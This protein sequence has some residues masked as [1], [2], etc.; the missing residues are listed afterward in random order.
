[1]I[2]FFSAFTNKTG[3]TRHQQTIHATKK[4]WICDVCGSRYGIKSLLKRHMMIHLPPSFACT[5]CDKKFVYSSNLRTHLK[6][7]A[8]ILNEVCKICNKGFST[9]QSLTDHT[10]YQHFSKLHCE[11]PNCLSKFALKS[12]YKYHLTAVHKKVDKEILEN[13]LEELEKLKPDH[14]QLKYV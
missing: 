3:L 9:K 11:I 5:Q 8:G 7:H 14:Q 2:S 13:L 12:N 4:D 6:G 10:I 1:M